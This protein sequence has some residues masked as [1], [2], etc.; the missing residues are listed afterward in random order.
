M[1]LGPRRRNHR[2]WCSGGDAS[3]GR[4]RAA[5]TVRV[6]APRLEGELAAA[7]DESFPPEIPTR[8]AL[9]AHE[10]ALDDVLDGYRGVVDAWKPQ[11]LVALHPGA[12]DEGVLYGTV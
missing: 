1:R 3:R 9:F 6:S 2:P 4:L 7:F 5:C 10:L 11:C 8:L 12:P